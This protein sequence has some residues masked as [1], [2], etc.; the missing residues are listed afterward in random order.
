MQERLRI[1]NGA[2]FGTTIKPASE[3]I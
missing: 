2:L 3:E 1:A